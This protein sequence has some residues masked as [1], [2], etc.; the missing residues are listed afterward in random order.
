MPDGS[1]G[2]A[3][4]WV[5]ASLERL[6]GVDITREACP[7]ANLFQAHII[8]RGMRTRRCR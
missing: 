6:V 2:A 3:D 5:Q 7:S 4:M 8:V 1:D